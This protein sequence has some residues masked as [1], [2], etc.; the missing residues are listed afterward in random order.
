[1]LPKKHHP[2]MMAT[3]QEVM[4]HIQLA[5][6]HNELTKKSNAYVMHRTN[7]TTSLFFQT[8]NFKNYESYLHTELLCF[9]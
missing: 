5:Y 6:G 1:M 9:I 8:N 7:T 4:F 3:I 2:D